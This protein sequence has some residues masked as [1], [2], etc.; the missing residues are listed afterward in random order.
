MHAPTLNWRAQLRAQLRAFARHEHW[1]LWRWQFGVL[2]GYYLLGHL[3]FS[4]SVS[5][6][7]VTSVFFAPEGLALAGA[8]L[9]G[10]RM[11]I[12]I[13][14][15]QLVLALDVG[16]A[17]ISS[18]LI[19]AI[20]TGENL[21]GG[22]LARRLGIGPRLD[23]PRQL[24]HLVGLIFLLLQ[25]LSAALGTLSLWLNDGLAS[26]DWGTAMRYWWFGNAM[27]Q[28]LIT[29]LLLCWSGISW[30]WRG[31]RQLLPLF[32]VLLCCAFYVA[33]AS[34]H[35]VFAALAHPLVMFATAY[36]LLAL[37]AL[38]SGMRGATIG[39]AVVVSVAVWAT[40][41]GI[42]PFALDSAADGIL[43][44]N[45][46]SLG[47]CIT[48]LLLAAVV[49]Q[50]Q[51]LTGQLR[52]Q[53]HH[54]PLTGVSSRR[55]FFLHGEHELA[56][57][58]RYRHPL[59]LLMLDIDHF[60]TIND[61]HGHA[62]GDEALRV[63]ASVIVGIVR[64]VDTVGRMGGEE[65]AVLLPHANALQARHIAERI[66]QEVAQLQ[67]SDARGERYGLTI[68]I[69][70]SQAREDDQHIETL[71]QRADQALYRAKDGGRDQVCEQAA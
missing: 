4:I 13:F 56:V 15:G 32:A 39:N 41:R 49:E 50:R 12:P 59:T 31:H 26:D 65:F 16:V 42:G 21:L 44:L 9:F 29:P 53:A 54:D 60:K 3:A 28:L 24:L 27:G 8:I 35:L 47:S 20:N 37:L 70:L 69:G 51:S 22:A 48:T 61:R 43:Y 17:P 63:V 25:P 5:H 40:H 19:A 68:S 57:A 67:L 64:Q 52:H 33:V 11:A 18:L 10:Y 36:P 46:F 34:G 62:A 7:N 45:A 30:R 38:F 55:Q 23:T 58:N 14:I 1:R 71:L 6:Q 66:R 2:C